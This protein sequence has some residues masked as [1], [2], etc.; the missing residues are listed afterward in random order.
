MLN[1]RIFRDQYGTAAMRQIFSDEVL[2][3][4][5]AQCEA[6]LARAQSPIGLVP[7]AAAEEISKHAETFVDVSFEDLRA[8]LHET[9]HPLMPFLVAFQGGLSPESARHVHWGATTQ[10]IMDTAV[11]L[12]MRDAMVLI[13][14]QLDQLLAVLCDM[15]LTF[16]NSPIAGRTH[17]QHAVPITFGLKIANLAAEVSRHIERITAAEDRILV[18]QLGGA[19]GSLSAM[20]DKA[21]E[22]RRAYCEE[23]DLVDPEA[24]WHSARDRL[25]EYVFLFSLVTMTAGRAALEVIELQRT[26]IAE[27][28]EP[29]TPG[30][31]GSSTM[32]QKVNPMISEVVVGLARLQKP[33]VVRML[34]GMVQAHERDMSTWYSEWACIAETSIVTSGALEQ[35]LDIYRGLNVDTQQM[36]SN[37]GISAGKIHAEAVMMEL[38][39][40]IGR[41]AAHE[42]VIAASRASTRTG[43]PLLHE[44]MSLSEVAKVANLDRLMKILGDDTSTT[45]SKEMTIATIARLNPANRDSK[46]G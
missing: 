40:H 44:L 16:A 34:D 43:E 26:E 24:T 4:K 33:Q 35:V 13:S 22:I 3:Q 18:G 21:L 27:V 11:V 45:P 23:L 41:P 8:S 31:I 15:A 12:Q 42:A 46:K 10:D 37:L 39:L 17:G 29:N 2:V 7:N 32:P 6:A 30:S 19:A 14:S 36:V 20:G 5:W 38:A 9:G 25:A 1:S 28:S